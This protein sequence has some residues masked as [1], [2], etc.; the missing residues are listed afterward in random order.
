[1]RRPWRMRTS[2]LS[3][4]DWSSPDALAVIQGVLKSGLYAPSG[5][6]QPAAIRGGDIAHQD[7]QHVLFPDWCGP[8]SEP[9][10]RSGVARHDASREEV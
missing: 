6:T 9:D 1:M 2:W 10:G 7:D 8:E 3:T 4:N 5:Q